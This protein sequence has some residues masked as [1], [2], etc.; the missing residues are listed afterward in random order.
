VQH[1]MFRSQTVPIV[2][3]PPVLQGLL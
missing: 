2:C 3:E 1:G